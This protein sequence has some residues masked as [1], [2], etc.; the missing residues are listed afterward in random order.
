M[1]TTFR[2]KTITM[3]FNTSTCNFLTFLAFP[4]NLAQNHADVEANT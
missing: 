4:G 3:H 2:K 1:G